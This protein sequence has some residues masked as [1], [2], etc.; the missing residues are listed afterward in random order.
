MTAQPIKS[1]LGTAHI[2]RVRA[3]AKI[4]L[5]LHVGDKRPDDFHALESLVVFAEEGDTLECTPATEL[6]LRVTGPFARALEGTDNLVLKAARA[7][8]AERGASITLDKQ[9]PVAAGLGGGSA[10]AAAALR[11]LNKLWG[12]GRSEKE[13]LEI[14]PNLGSDVPACLLSRPV[15]MEGRGERLLP[16]APFPPLSLILVNP[17]VMVPTKA[18][19][20]GLNLRNGLGAARPPHIH[21]VWELVSYLA[22][23][24]NDLEAPASRL[25]PIINVV[26]EAIAHEPG[27]VLAQ[28]SGSGA[29]CFG[30]FQDGPW[31]QGAADRL[32]E[33]HPLWWVRATRIAPPDYGAPETAS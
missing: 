11:A 2:L 7:L 16:V 14:A 27:C 15:W 10:D 25:A 30:L 23:S 26:L 24:E 22:D 29:S 1:R 5:F 32:T 20:A 8:D 31:A 4:N 28:M 13:L 17:R 18:V 33:D 9:L 21:D 3:P 6:S 19:F 12:L